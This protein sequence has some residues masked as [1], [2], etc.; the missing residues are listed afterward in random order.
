MISSGNKGERE[1]NLCCVIIK[2]SPKLHGMKK[3]ILFLSVT[4]ICF[5]SLRAQ[6]IKYESSFKTAKN[7]ALEQQRPLAVLITIQ[8]PIPTPN[9]MNGLNDGAVIEKFNNSFINYKAERED[10]A[11]SRQII[12]EYKVYR[13][14][15]FIFLDAKGGLM[16][17]DVAFL[18]R[19]QPLLDMA[20]KA[21]AATKEKS[22]ADYDSEYS[23]GSNSTA[24]LK[25]YILRRESAG[26]NNNADL[27]E[28]YVSGL[29]VHDLNNYAEVLFILK[30]GPIA[31]SNAY[32]LAHTNKALIDSIFKTEPLAD[33]LAINNS[34]IANTLN[35]AIANKNI[36][37]ASVAANF[38]RDSWANNYLEGQKNWYLKM[39]QYYRGVK[40]TINYLQIASTF[41][42]QYY[43]R[44]SIDSIRKRDSSN[45]EIA[46][47]KTRENAK[48]S[49]NDTA[50]RR[51]YSFAFPKDSFANDLN[52]AAW[53]FYQTAGSNNDYLLKA[54]L[55]SK[56]SIELSP[57]STFYDTYAHLLYKLKFY[58]EAE[59][60]QR[61]AVESGRAEKN[62]TKIFEQ[63]Y[64]KIKKRS[65]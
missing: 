46:K 47:N 21:I 56:R 10:T 6:K 12:S 9:F 28:K 59:S 17:T 22:L 50:I 36:A 39:L 23:R 58:D 7:L 62:D 31:D 52:N 57:K 42:D 35:N 13:F 63:E 4:L 54:M 3:T 34:T 18:S 20:N 43:M 44:I 38:T 60:M 64:E 48:L 1:Y 27:I 24:F 30:A 26:I 14:P 53:S 2:Y 29:T 5:V 40:D 33:R 61:K 49:S 45:F 32:K 19:P 11:A 25:S 37:R 55:W 51:T 16:F 41:Y 65:L 15:S 8:P